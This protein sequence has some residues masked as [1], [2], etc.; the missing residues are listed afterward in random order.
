MSAISWTA[1]PKIGQEKKVRSSFSFLTSSLKLLFF[2]PGCLV[3]GCYLCRYGWG[4]NSHGS[5]RRKIW[6]FFCQYISSA[7]DLRLWK[8][9]FLSFR[10][11]SKRYFHWTGN[12]VL[13]NI[14]LNIPS[15]AMLRRVP[16]Y[17]ALGTVHIQCKAKRGI[18]FKISNRQKMHEWK[19]W[20]SSVQKPNWRYN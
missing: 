14:Y 1:F 3:Q 19:K 7:V 16:L 20:S 4:K 12:N 6:T 15:M 18:H 9:N 13:T 10:D 5:W 17:I 11:K 8:S 2:F